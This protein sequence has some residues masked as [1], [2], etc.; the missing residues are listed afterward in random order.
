MLLDIAGRLGFV[1]EP[2]PIANLDRHRVGSCTTKG[3]L[4]AVVPGRRRRSRST[5]RP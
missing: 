5:N 4:I 2:G 1:A 3:N